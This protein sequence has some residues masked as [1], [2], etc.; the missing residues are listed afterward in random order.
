MIIIVSNIVSTVSKNTR[1][2]N[3][4]DRQFFLFFVFAKL[5]LA[6]TNSPAGVSRL[7]NANFERLSP[8]VCHWMGALAL[9]LVRA[10]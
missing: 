8:T 1:I 9:Q 5:L 2:V 4:Q 10:P 7:H 6:T 3:T